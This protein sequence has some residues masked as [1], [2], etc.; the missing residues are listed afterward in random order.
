[1]TATKTSLL[2]ALASSLM[3]ATALTPASA[4]DMTHERALN[5]A[6]EPQNW[7]LHHGNYQGHR[8]SALKEINADTVKNM[9]LAYTVGLGGFEGAG[10]RYKFGNLEATP[11]VE[12]GIMYVPDG[13]GTVYAIDV[14]NGRRGAIKWKMDP[15]TNKAW[16]GDVACCGVNNRGVALWKDKVISVTL[17]G[18][19]IATN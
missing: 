1:M 19:L 8:F 3:L 16:A 12:D 11:I 18:R 5:V 15:E 10:T 17:D 13:W 9:K 14:S 6:K 7:L 2:S 4:A